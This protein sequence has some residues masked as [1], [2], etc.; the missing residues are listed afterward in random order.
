MNRVRKRTSDGAEF[1]TILI[2]M[3]EQVIGAARPEYLITTVSCDPLGS[4][5][6]VGYPSFDI[7]KI[8]TIKEAV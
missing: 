1:L 7:N 6:P 8:N 5:I 3:S 2:N 4:F